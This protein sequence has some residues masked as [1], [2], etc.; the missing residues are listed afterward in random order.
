MIDAELINAQIRARNN[1][2]FKNQSNFEDW[3]YRIG[4]GVVPLDNEDY[5]EFAKRIAKEA[6][7]GRQE[8]GYE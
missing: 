6:W 1:D 2:S 4:S 5:E 3:W 8:Y 7:N